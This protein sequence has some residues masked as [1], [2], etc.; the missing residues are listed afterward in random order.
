MLRTTILALSAWLTFFSGHIE[1]SSLALSNARARTP[2]TR[3]LIVSGINKQPAQAR[4]RDAVVMLLKVQFGEKLNLAPDHIIVLVDD[5]SS[6]S[7]RFAPATT[8]GLRR[9]LQIL[10]A[11]IRPSDRFIFYY[12]GQA[13]VVA[14][15]LRFNVR[16]PDFTHVELAEMISRIKC[17]EKLIILDCPGAGLATEA[18]AG[19][20][21][22]V[23]SAARGDQP[24]STSFSMYF[25]PALLNAEND[26]DGDGLVSL[27][28]AFQRTAVQVDEFFISHQLL[29]TEVPLLE[30]DGDGVPSQQPWQW[31]TEGGD[32]RVASSFF[33]SNSTPLSRA[34]QHFISFLLTT[35]WRSEYRESTPEGA[36]PRSPKRNALTSPADTDAQ[37]NPPRRTTPPPENRPP[38]IPPENRSFRTMLR[39][40]PSSRVCR[41][42]SP[43]NICA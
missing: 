9:T 16:G 19:H 35:F 20:G 14:G 32:G 27:L 11:Q 26:T 3:L 4:I 25:V 7:G 12:T 15:K 30:D 29:C 21:R 38:K 2:D 8:A 42:R 33:L 34:F 17:S 40:V 41:T 37:T 18:L 43:M 39:S 1:P 28:E 23:I 22:I 5:D 6:V 13:N 24:Y 10:A 31:L 36:V